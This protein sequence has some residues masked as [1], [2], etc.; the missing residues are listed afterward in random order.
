MERQEYSREVVANKNELKDGEMKEVRIGKRSVLLVRVKGKFYAIGSRCSH[1]G[2]P[3]AKGVLSRCRV[4]CPWHQACFDA[5]TGD[6]REPPALNAL[7]CFDVRVKGENVIV[8]IPEDI[9]IRRTPPMAKR[10]PDKDNRTFVIVGGGA[11]GAIAAEALRQNGFEGR[12]IMIIREDRLPYDRTLL[13]KG[14]LTTDAT[15]IPLLRS[16]KFY[17]DYDIEVVTGQEIVSVN[18][19]NKIIISKGGSTLKYDKLLIATGAEP[20]RLTIPGAELEGI[21]TLRS[22]DDAYK[23]KSAL[24]ETSCVVVIGASFI[25]MEAAATFIQHKLPVTVVALESAPFEPVLGKKIGNL[26]KRVWQERG[27]SFRLN[28]KVSRFEGDGRVQEVILDDGEHLRTD[29]VLLGAGVKPTSPSIE[30]V[31]RN[32]DG[33]LPV[34]ELLQVSD[35]VYAAGDVASFINSQTGDRI[36]VEHWRLAQQHGH[37]AAHNMIGKELEFRGIP[38]F[39]TGEFGTNLRY[40]GHATGWDDVIFHGDPS[41]GDFVAFYIKD[42]KVLAAAGCNNDTKLAAVAELMR[43]GR[44]PGPEKLRGEIPDLVY[45]LNR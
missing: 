34:N 32:P 41:N 10:N 22:L 24:K 19:S 27:V 21:F 25:G 14:Y 18:T 4:R 16:E 20:R 45:R 7:P 42:G 38:F 8:S 13:T 9:E 39:W 3:L 31:K 44:M 1:R 15:R 11:A 12:I 43:M 6:V 17:T 2:A 37:V 40:V 23:I 28:T 35:D 30:G 5:T 26:F 29:L 36:R 33:S